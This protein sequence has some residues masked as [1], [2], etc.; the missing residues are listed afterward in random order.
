MNELIN[1]QF[2]SHNV[3]II[4]VDS[5]PWFV[6]KDV[7]ESLEYSD[8]EAMTRR[9]ED[10]EKA[11]RQVV[12][13][14]KSFI[15][16]SESGLYE[17][18]FGSKKPNAKEFKRWVKTEVLPSIRKT[19][20]YK[21]PD[22]PQGLPNFNNPVEAARAWADV[23]ESEQ[24]LLTQIEADKE[25]V[26][27][28][29]A[30]ISNSDTIDFQAAAKELGTGRNTLF[31]LC[32]NAGYLMTEKSRRNHPYQQFINQGYFVLE[33]RPVMKENEATGEEYEQIFHTPMITGKGL[34]WLQRKHFQVTDEQLRESRKK[35]VDKRLELVTP[36][37][38]ASGLELDSHG[39]DADLER[40][41]FETDIVF[42]SRIVQKRHF[43]GEG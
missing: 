27:F 38:L 12:G 3:R 36:L 19:G 26:D 14:R 24:S 21:M 10:D 2:E 5:E 23:K 16:V 7:A 34:A 31:K 9:L 41:E 30:M 29:D 18:I 15:T 37:E 42:R 17:C 43:N 6:A 22:V 4:N 1:K 33:P 8:A 20:Q 35:S 11:N 13:F 40:R 39:A 25:K 28:H 32:R